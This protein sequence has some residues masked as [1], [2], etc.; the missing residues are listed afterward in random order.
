MMENVAVAEYEPS[1]VCAVCC[2]V[3]VRSDVASGPFANASLRTRPCIDPGTVT[4]N[5]VRSV[6][7]RSTFALGVPALVV[8]LRSGPAAI[9]VL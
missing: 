3:R 4:P 7:A 5:I 1:V 8:R 6:G 9:N 2:S